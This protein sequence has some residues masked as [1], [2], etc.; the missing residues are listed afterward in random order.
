MANILIDK[1]VARGDRVILYLHKSLG[2]VVA[3]LALQKIGA[4]TVPLNPGF[5][6]SEMTYLI[7]DAEPKMVIAGPE[8]E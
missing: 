6:P 5:T 7:K 1:G 4:V 8:Q 2:L 3:H